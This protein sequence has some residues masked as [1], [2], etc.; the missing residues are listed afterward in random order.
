MVA[1]RRSMC[2]RRHPTRRLPDFIRRPME[3]NMPKQTLYIT[4]SRAWRLPRTT[5]PAFPIRRC[6]HVR[7]V[8]TKPIPAL[9]SC[10]LNSPQYPLESRSPSIQ[11]DKP[12]MSQPVTKFPTRTRDQASY[13]N[14]NPARLDATSAYRE[15]CD[16]KPEDRSATQER[17]DEIWV[18]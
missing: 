6:R 8:S 7:V 12:S 10:A 18:Q 1:A 16:M 13:S 9:I 11:R 2:D 14:I 5:L 15:L 4:S 17:Q 3:T